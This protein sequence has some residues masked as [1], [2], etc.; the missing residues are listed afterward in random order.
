[1]FM[2]KIVALF[3]VVL[4][5][6]SAQTIL[7]VAEQ[8]P[9]LSSFVSAIEAAG[10]S[11]LLNGE[12][13][14][15]LFAPTNA[16]FTQ[17]PEEDLT[18]L[19]NDPELLRRILNYHI[20]PAFVMASEARGLTSAPTLEGSELGIRVEEGNLLINESTVVKFDVGASEDIQASNGVIHVIDSVLVPMGVMLGQVTPA[21]ETPSTP[22]VEQLYTTT[23]LRSV[24]YPVNPVGESSVSGSVLVADYGFENAV[25]TLALSGTTPEG[26]HPTHFHLGNCSSNGEIIVPLENLDGVT[27][28]SV[29]TMT[30]PYDAIVEGDHYLNVHL[31]EE[32]VDTIIACG[33]AGLGAN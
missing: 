13:P 21:T 5:I 15:T 11:D 6:G 14:F 25:V 18:T 10:L 16:A 31:S 4:S 3:F 17:I 33:E 7:E 30:A 23:A 19:L 20:V 28:L 8:D 26:N 22:E 1:M 27:G 32:A 24:R 12:G 29:T 2:K 9:G